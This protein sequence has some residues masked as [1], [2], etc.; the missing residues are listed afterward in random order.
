MILSKADKPPLPSALAERSIIAL[1]RLYQ[2]T[3]SPLIGR[4]CRFVPSCSEYFIQAVRK[5]GPCR[6]S[7]MGIWRIVRCN[8]FC[9]GGYDPVR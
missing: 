9:R 6:G 3:L 1:V 5:H 2:A 7:L 4:Q 8:P